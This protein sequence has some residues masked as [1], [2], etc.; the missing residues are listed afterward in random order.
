[1]VH[2]NNSSGEAEAGLER[3]SSDN[4]RANFDFSEGE[5]GF[6][7]SIVFVSLVAAFLAGISLGASD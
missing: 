7:G 6:S 4:N 3:L 1:M 5:R 2:P